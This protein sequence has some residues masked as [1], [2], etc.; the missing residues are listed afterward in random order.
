MTGTRFT[1]YVPTTVNLV[2]IKSFKRNTSKRGV[3]LEVN[4]VQAYN[5]TLYLRSAAP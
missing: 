2:P 5:N 3:N 1:Y 4:P